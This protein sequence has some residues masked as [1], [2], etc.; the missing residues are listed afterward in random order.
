MNTDTLTAEEHGMAQIVAAAINAAGP[1][2]EMG[3]GAVT[4]WQE[5]VQDVADFGVSVMAE[6]AGSGID[7]ESY[8]QENSEGKRVEIGVLL[9]IHLYKGRAHVAYQTPWAEVEILPH[10]EAVAAWEKYR[11]DPDAWAYNDPDKDEPG[12]ILRGDYGIQRCFI[13]K[14]AT[15]EGGRLVR[16]ARGFVGRA[17]SVYKRTEPYT[18]NKGQARKKRIVDD[19]MAS[20]LPPDEVLNY[21]PVSKS[22]PKSAVDGYDREDGPR[23][24][25]S[26][27]RGRDDDDDARG[28]RGRDDD[29]DA[30]GRR[31]RDDDDARG[32]RSRDG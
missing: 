8:R 25:R 30:R 4:E 24:R 22:K 7:H 2:P 18:N 1:F 16:R 17:V 5:R 12:G 28:R 14:P 15:V 13:D 11:Y 9:G 31:G 10:D 19:I 6:F 21:G 23:A 20:E 27:S 32:R 26:R 3:N 29:D